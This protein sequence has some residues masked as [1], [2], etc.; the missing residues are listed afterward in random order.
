MMGRRTLRAPAE[1]GAVL[2]DPPL[3][4]VAGL[5]AENR[6]RLATGPALL[7]RPWTELRQLARTEARAMARTYFNSLHEPPPASDSEYLVLAGHQP[8]LIH[9]GVWVKNFV[10]NRLARDQGLTP[11]NLIVDYD[12]AKQPVLQVPQRTDADPAAVRLLGLSPDSL[13]SQAPYEELESPEDL[14]LRTFASRVSTCLDAW[15][16]PSL[17]SDFWTVVREQAARSLVLGD[18][19]AAARRTF[20]RRWNCANWEVPVSDLCRTESFAHFTR[21]LLSDLPRFHRIYNESVR[22]YRRVYGIRSLHHP[23]P[24]LATGDD[25]WLEA[26]FWAWERGAK[27]RNRLFARVGPSGVETLPQGASVKLRPRAITNTLFARLFVA[28]VFLHGIGGAKYDELTDEIIRRYYGVE[29]PEYLVVSGTLRLPL[30]LQPGT[31]AQRRAL[32]QRLRSFHWNPHRH[33]SDAAAPRPETARLLAERAQWIR[34]E[35]QTR[36]GRRARF[37]AL[38]AATERLRP[39]VADEALRIQDA[40]TQCNRQLAVNAI[41]QRRDYAACLFPETLLRTFLSSF[42]AK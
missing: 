15:S 22:D 42:L 31:D 12:T 41:L 1:D 24:E 34:Q 21:H 14:E 20:E 9:P 29:P 10:L 6:R 40:L 18:C 3:E 39:Q 8:E 7:G 30:P 33:L 16:L 19:F 32:Q 5:L 27:R 35:P 37:A 36:R 25:G 28:D 13:I 38:R 11:L 17:F 4:Q 26:P 2:I 23:V